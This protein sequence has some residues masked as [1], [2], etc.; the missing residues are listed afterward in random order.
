MGYVLI[1]TSFCK[2]VLNKI[3]FITAHYDTCV[4][5]SLCSCQ[6]SELLR[7]CLWLVHRQ[8]TRHGSQQARGVKKEAASH[9]SIPTQRKVTCYKGM[10]LNNWARLYSRASSQNHPWFVFSP[11][12]L[13]MSKWLSQNAAGHHD[14][15]GPYYLTLAPSR[16]RSAWWDPLPIVL[17]TF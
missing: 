13:W 5:T 16:D 6:R 9:R 1:H 10:N 8:Q 4:Y 17:E 7:F 15:R 12:W 3:F 14:F 2:S 11:N